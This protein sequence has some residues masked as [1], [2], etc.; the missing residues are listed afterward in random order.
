MEGGSEVLLFGGKGTNSSQTT[1]GSISGF[2]VILTAADADSKQSKP[3]IGCQGFRVVHAA[4]PKNAR[5]DGGACVCSEGFYLD[6]EGCEPCTSDAL[7]PSCPVVA[8]SSDQEAYLPV[9]LLAS[10]GGAAGFIAVFVFSLIYAKNRKKVANLEK[11]LYAQIN[12]E[13][14]KIGEL[15][16]VGGFGEVYKGEWRGTEVAVKI[17]LHKSITDSTISSFMA[18]IAVMVELRHPNIVLYM[19]ASIDPPN[20]CLVCELMQGGTLFSLLHRHEIA[21]PLNQRILFML[22]ISKGMQ[23]LHSANPPILHHDLKS[24]NVLLDE[25]LHAKVSDFGLTVA[26]SDGKKQDATGSLLWLAPE[27]I[28]DKIYGTAADVY[29]FAIV[30]WEIMTRKIPFADEESTMAVAIRVALQGHRPPIDSNIPVQIADIIKKC[31]AQ[32]HEDRPSFVQVAH[33]IQALREASVSNGSSFQS[34][35]REMDI[36]QKQPIGDVCFVVSQLA[37]NDFLWEEIPELIAEAIYTHNDLM[38]KIV[39]SNHGI[40]VR[41]EGDSF[42]IVFQNVLDGLRFTQALQERL[43]EYSWPEELLE[44]HLCKIDE[45]HSLRGPRFRM[46]IH[47]GK[48]SQQYDSNDHPQYIGKVVNETIKLCRQIQGGVTVLSEEAEQA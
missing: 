23:Y 47:Y 5:L 28:Q 3:C 13:D 15:I 8:D 21:I 40:I 18:E 2:V 46:A 35:K 10:V 32:D 24:L 12:Y 27:F 38:R 42:M 30:A 37:D 26:Q 11:K 39:Q 34:F 19:G 31:W 1:L 17:L 43:F 20:L 44:H 4:C 25:H 6:G 22:N 16:G 36:E 45:T 14:L 33:D 9:T 41:N 7:N 48:S 29:S